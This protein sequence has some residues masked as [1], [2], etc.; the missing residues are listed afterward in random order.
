VRF[1]QEIGEAGEEL[2]NCAQLLSRLTRILQI[3]R[4]SKPTRAPLFQT[5]NEA[6]I[7]RSKRF[8]IVAAAAV[9]ALVSS[10]ALSSTQA[11][12]GSSKQ[13]DEGLRA[14]H[15]ASALGEIMEAPDQSIP[16][17]LLKKAYGIAVIPHVVKGAFG[18]GG[19][20]GKGLIAQRNA[21][22]GWGTPLFIEIGGGSFGFQLGVEATDLVMVFTNSDGIKPLLRGKLKIGAD[23]S[24]TAGPVGRNAEAGTDILLNSAIYSYSRSKGLFAGVALDGAVLQLDDDANKSVYGKK[25]VA[26]DLSVRKVS[27][28]AMG[29]VQPF[30]RALQKYAGAEAPKTTRK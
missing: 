27:V 4:E 8:L 20:Y 16:E 3:E 18:L 10:A 11:R 30:L 24:A 13:T 28:A 12:T 9:V 2:S 15:A 17:A 19:R 6:Q 7:M 5:R 1:V 26:A 14:E 23:A 22:G 29:V 25:S 21:G